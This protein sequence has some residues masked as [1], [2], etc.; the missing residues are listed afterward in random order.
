MQLTVV[1]GDRT[2]RVP[3]PDLL[4]ATVLKAAAWVTDRRDRERHSGD[5]AFLVSLIADPL[6]QRKRFAGSDRRRLRQLGAVLDD[7]DAL[8]WRILCGAAADGHAAWQ[9]LRT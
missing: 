9:L 7:P 8:E 1:K 3:V 4:G 5:A 6:A 2:A